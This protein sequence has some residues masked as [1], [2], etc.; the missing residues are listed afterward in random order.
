[1]LNGQSDYTIWYDDQTMGTNL[2]IIEAKRQLAHMLAIP[3][4]LAYMAMVHSIRKTE[5]LEN[6]IVFGCCS[7][8]FHF[9]FLRIDNEGKY[10]QS[11]SIGWAGIPRDRSKIW[12]HLCHILAAA[13]AS[14]PRCSLK[15]VR[16][17]IDKSAQGRAYYRLQYGSQEDEEMIDG[18]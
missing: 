4:C 16:R 14:S 9:V 12:T 3:Q 10:P 11:R 7:D 5:G 1:M 6:S 15:T 2:V 8:S 17:M 13:S 18:P